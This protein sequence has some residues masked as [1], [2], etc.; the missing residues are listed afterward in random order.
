MSFWSL[1]LGLMFT[2]F[3]GMALCFGL[4]KL[5]E[6]MVKRFHARHAPES[7]STPPLQRAA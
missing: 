6:K 2:M 1:I 7:T 3:G 4:V 5:G